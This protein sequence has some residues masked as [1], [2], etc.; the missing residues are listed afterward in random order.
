MNQK[1]N[2]MIKLDFSIFPVLQ[3]ERLL[4]RSLQPSDE[5]EIFALRSDDNINKYIDRPKAQT[6][7]DAKHFIERITQNIAKNETLFWVIELKQEHSFAG[8]ALLWNINKENNEAEI[9]YELL[10]QFHGKGIISEALKAVLAFAFEKLKIE[11]L[12]AVVHKEN[13][14]SLKV[15][16]KYNFIFR[17]ELEN[18]LHEYKLNSSAFTAYSK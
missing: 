4:L 5:N 9:G 15:L 11:T 12:L 10:P 16:Q 18:N 3:T 2:Q 13:I 14:A 7:D 17:T 1:R 8:T 6:K